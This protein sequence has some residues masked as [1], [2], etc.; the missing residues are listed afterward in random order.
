MPDISAKDVAALRKSS[1]AGMMDCKRALEESNGDMEAAKTWLREK[2]LAAAGKRAGRAASQG[3]VDVFVEGPIGAVV[4]LTCETDFVAKGDGFKST[5][6]ALAKQAAEQGEDIAGKPYAGDPTQTVD[7]LVKSMAGSLGENIGLGRVARF[8]VNGGIIEGYK[9]IQQERGTIGVLVELTGVDPSDPKAV[10]V[11]HDIALHIASA[12]PRWVSREDVPADV[13]ESERAVLEN[14]TRNEGKPEQ[15]IGKIVE[16]RIGGF[17]KEN[18]LLEQGFVRDP[19]V[20]VGSLLSG[21]GPEA[22]I[23]RFARIK[24]GED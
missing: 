2:G 10:E 20:V 15:A 16:G 1:G 6:T 11:G 17:Y 5:V 8:E 3:A 22:K 13:I 9:H 21:L 19:K 4:E 14:L 24:V 23:T 18:C 7:D 12:A